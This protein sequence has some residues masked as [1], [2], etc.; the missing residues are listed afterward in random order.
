M[1]SPPEGKPELAVIVTAFRRREY[2]P[3]AL[4]SVLHQTV[5]RDAYE[6]LA[7]TDFTDPDLE[8]L[9]SGAGA[10]HRVD[11]E[12]RIGKWLLGAIDATRAPLIAIV[13]D[14][15]LLEPGRFA[16]ALRVFHARPDLA[17][18]RNRVSVI[19]P[20]GQPLPRSHWGRIETERALDRRGPQVIASQEK[21]TGVARMRDEG[22]EWLNLSSMIFRREI[23]TSEL[24]APIAASHCPDLFT[25]VAAVLSPGGLY[26]DD[27]RMTRYRR[28][29]RG[30]TRSLAW[31]R[32][33]AA[34]HA[35]FAE[36]ARHRGPPALAD[37]LDERAQM[38]RRVVEVG[39]VLEPLRAH[40]DTATSTAATQRY[41]RQ[42][43]SDRVLAPPAAL[44]WSAGAIASAYRV[45]PPF[46][47]RLLAEC[48][49]TFDLP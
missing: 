21:E 38:L 7:L 35:R 33:H 6:L 3:L 11:D 39:E 25:F 5:P 2:L 9:L 14:D 24:R 37:W 13:E 22:L 45:A 20:E 44:R 28:H 12:L 8:R 19:G 16:R 36:I 15:D 29:P 32:L 47:R 31:R 40:S 18:Y 17:Y 26:L 4:A 27:Q 41:L 48:D 46:A 34:D 49:R 10:R 1:R 42:L 43:V 23:V 30:S